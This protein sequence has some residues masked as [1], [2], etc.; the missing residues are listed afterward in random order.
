MSNITQNSWHIA[1][2]TQPDSIKIRY[3]LYCED[4][5]S[6]DHFVVFINGHGE[7]IEKYNY[8]P[9][10]LKLPANYA[11]LTWD[12]RGQGASDGEPRLHIEDYETLAKDAQHV[13]NTLVGNKPYTVVAHSM[14]GLIALYATMR[15]YIKPNHLTLSRLYS[16]YDM[17][18]L[19]VSLATAKLATK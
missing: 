19:K 17:L 4:K 11:F 2:L 3:G 18:Y 1:S 10:D 6:I 12:H 5:N 15:S 7:F 16:V 14:G 8:L 13:I 9:E